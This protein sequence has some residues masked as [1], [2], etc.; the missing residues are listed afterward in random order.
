MNLGLHPRMSWDRR[1]GSARANV[2]FPSRE[3]IASWYLRVHQSHIPVSGW[4]KA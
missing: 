3:E 1:I 2:W 4:G